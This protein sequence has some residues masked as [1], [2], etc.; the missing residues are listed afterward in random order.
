MKIGICLSGI[1][2]GYKDDR[3]FDHC[4][5]SFNEKILKPLKH[6][7]EVE[8]YYTTYDF[9]NSEEKLSN[10]INAKRKLIIP[11]DGSNQNNTRVKCLNLV[12]EDLDFCILTR[13]DLHYLNDFDNFNL[14]FEKINITSK[15]GNGYWAHHNYVGDTFFAWNTKYNEVILKS[16]EQMSYSNPGH[17]HNFY[18]T[19]RGLVDDEDIHFMSEEE[20][21]SGHKFASICQRHF[22]EA[23][24]KNFTIDEEVLKRFNLD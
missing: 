18:T 11:Y 20:Q 6:K 5:P 1:S 7:H 2:Y 24:S 19:I 8:V 9:I 23:N 3:N 17:S 15:E 22:V 16:F 21:A 13:F 14:D 10:L 12:S 4:Y